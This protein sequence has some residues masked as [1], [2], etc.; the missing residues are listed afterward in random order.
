MP[1]TV[2][3]GNVPVGDGQPT[4]FVAEIGSFFKKDLDL[5]MDFLKRTVEAGAP[6]FK[7]EILHDPNVVLADS[8]L[9]CNF[10]HAGGKRSQD[11][12][13]LIEER[14]FPLKNYEKLF[15]ACKKFGVP[16][17]ASVFDFKGVDFLK[18]VGGA[19][20]KLSRNYIN[21]HVLMRYAAESGLPVILDIGEAYFSETMA[22]VELVRAIGA[23]LILNHHPG[24]NPSPAAVHNLRILDTYKRDMDTPVG[25]SCHYR[26]DLMLYAATAAGANLLEKGVVDDPDAAEAD[27]VSAARFSELKTILKNVRACWEALGDG[28]DHTPEDRDLSTRAGLVADRD[29]K[30]GSA[31]ALKDVRFA[32]PPLGI[33]PDRWA[34]VEGAKLAT[35]VKAGEPITWQ[36]LGFSEDGPQ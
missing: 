18:E 31:L 6:V 34:S 32:W 11:Y 2:N 15:A 14:V 1:E 22:A 35:P 36:H 9:L 25:L 33:P 24:P 30:E 8:G 26:G 23:P 13:E 27:I 5:A 3:I 12:R 29:L 16:A 21:H 7:T 19:A 20:V 28:R 4:V 17:I 10:N